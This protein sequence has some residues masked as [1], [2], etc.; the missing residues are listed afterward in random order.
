MSETSKFTQDI[1]AVAKEKAQSIVAEAEAETKRGLEDA[2]VDTSRQASDILRNAQTEAEAVRRRLMS[3]V[4]HRLKL[5]EQEEKGKM[6]SEVLEATRKRV[7]DFVKNETQVK[8]QSYLAGLIGDAV[9]E[10]G[11]GE[12]QVHLNEADQKRLDK[13]LLEREVAKTLKTPVK[14]EWAKEPIVAM[15]GAIVSSTDG[16]TRIINTLDE[17]FEALEPKLLIEAGKL[18]FG[19]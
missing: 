5:R 15:G 1:L 4:R 17:R 16:R 9:R 12:A 6:M 8:Y 11:L 19:D 13:T 14:I 7:G 3:E 10:L 2:K 18:L